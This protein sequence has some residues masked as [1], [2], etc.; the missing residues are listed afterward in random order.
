MT[1]VS[2]RMSHSIGEYNGREDKNQLLSGAEF[3]VCKWDALNKK[4]SR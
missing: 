2:S 3:P 1:T 4:Q